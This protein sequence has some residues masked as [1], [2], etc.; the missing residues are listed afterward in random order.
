MNEEAWR[1]SAI[2]KFGGAFQALAMVARSLGVEVTGAQISYQMA[3][4]RTPPNG[5]DVV[6]AA[7]MIGLKARLIANPSLRR[8]R[9][10]PTPALARL[11]DGSWWIFGGETTP[12]QYRMFDPISK[13]LE[14]LPLEEVHKRIDGDFILIGKSLK[15]SASDVA[16]ASAGSCPRSSAIA[17]R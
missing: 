3:Q 7:Q 15:M 10:A 12:G 2:P 11:Q 4:G 17:S 8:L 16:L 6:R 13:E 1:A 14:K 9:S 5:A